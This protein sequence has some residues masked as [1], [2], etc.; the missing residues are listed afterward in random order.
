[1]T[2]LNLGQ[3]R[4][5]FI[6]LCHLGPI[7]VYYLTVGFIHDDR[8]HARNDSLAYGDRDAGDDTGPFGRNSM[9]HLHHYVPRA[10][11]GSSTSLA[12]A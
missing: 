4:S 2:L 1:M 8:W 12:A 9:L 5:H 10:K 3:I 6:G 7:L 11:K